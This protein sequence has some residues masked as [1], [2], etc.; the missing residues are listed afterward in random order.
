MIKY[1]IVYGRMVKQRG[2]INWTSY[3]QR[4]QPS[5]HGGR[6]E[7]RYATLLNWIIKRERRRYYFAVSLM[8]IV[9]KYETWQYCSRERGVCSRVA[10]LAAIRTTLISIPVFKDVTPAFIILYI[11]RWKC[12]FVPNVITFGTNVGATIWLAKYTLTTIFFFLYS[13][14]TSSNT[15]LHSKAWATV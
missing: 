15:W 13:A 7:K 2:I 10:V 9:W 5:R 8:I 12:T 14:Y 6:D 3:G 4:V 1:Q 11:H